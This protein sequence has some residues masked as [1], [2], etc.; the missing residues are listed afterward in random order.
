M[1]FTAKRAE[2]AIRKTYTWTSY[3]LCFH[4]S[5]I[6]SLVVAFYLSVARATGVSFLGYLLATEMTL[7]STKPPIAMPSVP[8]T[9]SLQ[10]AW[11]AAPDMPAAV[12]A[13]SI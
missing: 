10:A 2:G 9:A 4:G 11:A 3:Q 5:T 12:C 1:C 6:N 8:L 7:L 13:I